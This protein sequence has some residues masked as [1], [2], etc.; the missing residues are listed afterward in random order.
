MAALI[1]I[2]ILSVIVIIHEA[3]HFI[4]AKKNK[5]NVREFGLGYPPRVLKLFNWKG[6]LFSLNLIPF[7]G[8]VQMDGENGPEDSS[9]NSHDSFYDKSIK[10]RLAV[11][12]AGVAFNF[13]FGILAFAFV[14]YKLGIPTQLNGQARIQ[15]VVANSPAAKANLIGNS[16]ILAFKAN[17]QW[18]E[19]SDISK[20]QEFASVHLG[21]TI[22][23]RTS[24]PCNQEIC[25]KE[26]Q[27]SSIYLRTKEETPQGEGSMGITFTD[28]IFKN[29][30]W[31]LMPFMTIFH[32]FKQSIALSLLIIQSLGQLVADLFAGRGIQQE[33]AGPIGIIDQANTY[34]FFDGGFLS[35]IN[36]AALL[37]IN[38]GIMNLLP[39]PALDGGRAVLVV[40]EK[41][42]KRK[43]IDKV[44]SYLNYFGY[45]SL[46][47][48][49]VIVS[50]NDIKNIFR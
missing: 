39:I 6:T 45:I 41:F 15:E 37:S 27:E 11:V 22:M 8:F 26:F 36:F 29:Y 42:F 28:V 1:F 18:V 31:Y 20:V 17:D 38:L 2:L 46:L 35:I 10:A 34:G 23:I 21:E 50:F 25:P 13:I 48:L 33:V 16:N 9:S 49:M 7:G 32:A 4:F 5:I 47:A 30:P 12:L 43:K 19:M 3:G 40:L 24:L 14:F 44:A